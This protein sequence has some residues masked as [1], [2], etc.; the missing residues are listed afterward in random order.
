M[1]KVISIA[2][3][4]FLACSCGSSAHKVKLTN[5]GT[6]VVEKEDASCK[7]WDND[8]A[9]TISGYIYMPSGKKEDYSS[10]S[11][12]AVDTSTGK[13]DATKTEFSIECEVAAAFGL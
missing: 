6:L 9:C 3:I 13:V 7:P 4:A 2:A 10:A 8:K 11:L 1:K 5:G 12:C